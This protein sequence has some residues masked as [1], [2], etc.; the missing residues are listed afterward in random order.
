[1][2]SGVITMTA[3]IAAWAQ[4]MPAIAAPTTGV[5]RNVANRR[6][7]DPP[8]VALTG[9]TAARWRGRLRLPHR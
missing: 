3:T 6:D 1:M 2:W 8:G 9:F 5:A 7:H 4:A